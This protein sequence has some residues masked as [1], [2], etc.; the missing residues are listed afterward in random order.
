MSLGLAI[1]AITFSGSVIAFAKLQALMSGA[2]I[3]FPY[4][5][6]LNPGIAALLVAADHRV[7]CHRRQPVRVLADRHPVV[8]HR[9]PADHP[10]RRRRHAGGRLDAEQLLGLGGLRHR[11]HHPEPRPD[12]HRRAG[13]LVRRDPVLHHV[14]G[15][16][17][18]HRQRAAGRVRR[19]DGGAG[20][21][22]RRRTR[23]RSRAATPTM[24]PSS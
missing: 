11:L 1:G 24:P 7:R 5:H 18:Q 2:P 8:R 4:Q 6:P 17:P 9:L 23:E 13:R 15:H 21:G 20:G 10:D 19:R 12:H 14:Q 16:E 22:R 3:T